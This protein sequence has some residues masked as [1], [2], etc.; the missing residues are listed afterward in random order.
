MS[1]TEVLALPPTTDLPTLGR[2]FG[3]SEPVIRERHRLGQLEELGIKVLPLG[4]Q[5]RVVTATVWDVLGLAQ[6]GSGAGPPGP[7]LAPTDVTTAAEQIEHL[8]EG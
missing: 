5:W 6:N 4:R 1:R 8:H 7:A 3:V 2:I